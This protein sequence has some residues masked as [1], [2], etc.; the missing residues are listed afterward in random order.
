MFK[1]NIVATSGAQIKFAYL[2]SAVAIVALLMVA[3]HIT[4]GN[5]LKP[6]NI[7]NV[8]NQAVVLSLLAT[9]MCFVMV[10]GGIDLS[11][12]SVLAISAIL[13]AI[14]MRDQQEVIGGLAVM[15]AVGFATGLL[16]GISVAVFGMAPFVVTLATTTVA[17][18][19]AVWLTQSQSISGFPLILTDIVTTR[20]LNVPLS[21]WFALSVVAVATIVMGRTAFGRQV[22]AVGLNSK[23][24]Q[25]ARIPVRKVILATYVIS[26][27]MA[28][29]AGALSVA[30][31]GSA[32]ALM[33]ADS[34]MLD[35]ISACVI[36]RVSVYGGVGRPAMAAIGALMITIISNLLN[37]MGVSFSVNLIVKG[38]I[39]DYSKLTVVLPSLIDR[40]NREVISN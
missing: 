15:A 14:Y 20:A 10:G 3:S 29:A 37:Q 7:I 40:W 22:Q 16:N 21:V 4:S 34:L 36:G 11:M 27:L 24:A 19:A 13:G 35:T 31:L 32:S 38:M 1:Q 26:G 2:V 30:R 8:A 5:F 18:G 12:P 9:G 25:V 6:N 28:A 17:G 39:I 23:A 33:G